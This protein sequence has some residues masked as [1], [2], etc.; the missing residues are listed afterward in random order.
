MVRGFDLK[1]HI[2]QIQDHISSGRLTKIQRRHIKIACFFMSQRRGTAFLVRVEQ[3][4]FTLRPY[5]EIISKLL[6]LPEHFLQDI[7]GIP[8]EWKSVLSVHVTDQS[9]D[10]SALGM[11]WKYEKAVQIRVQIH[12]GFFYPH[13]TV[14]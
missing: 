13:K 11:P 7:A 8:D 4:E 14:H 6:A 12:V 1:S 9:R 2:L 3:K 10:F 5:I